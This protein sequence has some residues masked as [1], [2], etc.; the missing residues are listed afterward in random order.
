MFE[1]PKGVATRLALAAMQTLRAATGWFADRAARL[2]SRQV[3]LATFLVFFAVFAVWSSATPMYGTPDETAHMVRAAGIVR[4]DTD[5]TRGEDGV[6]RFEVPAILNSGPGCYAFKPDQ[7]AS[8]MVIPADVGSADVRS[9]ASSYPPLFHLAVGWPTLVF[10]GLKSLYLMRFANA[11]ACAALLTLAVWNI[12]ALSRPGP[13]ALA[14]GVSLT[15]MVLFLSGP[16]NP[17]GLATSAG[18]A[19]WSAGFVLLDPEARRSLAAAAASFAIPFCVL[20]L[21]RRDSLIWGPA[22]V[23]VLAVA[24]PWQ[25]LWFLLRQRVIWVCAAVISATV[26]AQYAIWTGDNAS[27]FTD[28]AEGAG[29]GSTAQAFGQTFRYL[30]EA[31][32]I[33]GWLD[34]RMPVLVY[35]GWFVLI[36]ALLLAVLIWAGRRDVVAVLLAV[37]FVIALP[38]YIGSVRFPYFQGRYYLPFAVGVPLLAARALAAEMARL[39]MRFTVVGFG[40]FFLLHQLAFTQH[41]RRYAVG[42]SGTWNFVTDH[43]W[44]PPGPPLWVF[45]AAYALSTAAMLLMLARIAHPE[46]ARSADVVSREVEPAPS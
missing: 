28:G 6:I 35:H 43:E 3:V 15:P 11:A 22:I 26:I 30:W 7:D 27:R 39:P 1:G 29:G 4:G 2:T 20:V 34:T 42:A 14:M 37:A 24:A 10:S 41:M 40:W 46:P 9:T 45:L 33:M 18:F 25:R 44:S 8:C 38:T 23:A 17:S 32:G 21:A 13:I 16:V 31:V 12:R 5:G 36:G 19:I